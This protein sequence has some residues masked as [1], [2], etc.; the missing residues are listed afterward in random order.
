VTTEDILASGYVVLD[1]ASREEL[2]Y[3]VALEVFGSVI[4]LM[5]QERMLGNI[6]DIITK[7]TVSF[8]DTTG[9]KANALSNFGHATYLEWNSVPVEQCP[10]SMLDLYSDSSL[11]RVAFFEDETGAKKIQL[12][13]P[14]MGTLKVWYEP[15]ALKANT[16]TTTAPIVDS[17]KWCLVYRWAEKALSYVKFTDERKEINKPVLYQRLHQDATEWRNIYLER[18]N[19]MGTNRPFSRL[20]FMGG[21]RID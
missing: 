4:N 10:V 5:E 3:A 16:K 20:P 8:T 9:I 6:D 11:Q 13:I 19:R 15:D 14:E 18:V 12:A 1:N 2:D 17:L 21:Q 7:S